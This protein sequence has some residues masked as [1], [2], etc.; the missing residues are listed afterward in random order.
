MG[1]L[2][3]RRGIPGLKPRGSPMRWQGRQVAGAPA[4]LVS[5]ALTGFMDAVGRMN[6][7]GFA[8]RKSAFGM[9][10]PQSKHSASAPSAAGRKLNRRLPQLLQLRGIVTSSLWR[11]PPEAKLQGGDRRMRFFIMQSAVEAP[12][13]AAYPCAVRR[14]RGRGTCHTNAT[15]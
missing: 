10:V 13:K 15:E 4:R 6:A 7:S 9:T 8:P 12:A 14:S 2:P 3:A 11:D 5:P 1:A